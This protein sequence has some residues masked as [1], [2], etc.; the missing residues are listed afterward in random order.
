M[1][2]SGKNTGL[3]TDSDKWDREHVS[4]EI[5]ENNLL[6]QKMRCF[7]THQRI[8]LVYIKQRRLSKEGRYEKSIPDGKK[9]EHTASGP[10]D[11]FK[12]ES[13]KHDTVEA[14]RVK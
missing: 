13:P 14:C 12:P 9:F 11:Q 8:S 10:D 7:R 1:Q 5:L 3:A 4:L 6:H 2:L